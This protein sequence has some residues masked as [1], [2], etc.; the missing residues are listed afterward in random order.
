[1]R[2]WSQLRLLRLWITRIKLLLL[3]LIW[4]SLTHLTSLILIASRIRI[5]LLSSSRWKLPRI[6]WLLLWLKTSS[7]SLIF[8]FAA[9]K[10]LSFKIKVC[11]LEN[12]TNLNS[13]SGLI[14][15]SWIVFFFLLLFL[16]WILTDYVAH[17]ITKVFWKNSH[18][19][20][21]TAGFLLR[22]LNLFR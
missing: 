11:T 21:M 22:C 19:E 14:K 9:I 12:N 3:L 17:D 16:A 8:I 10:H 15:G 18:F 6:P 4:K 20:N 13:I 1:M 2:C 5:I 7:V